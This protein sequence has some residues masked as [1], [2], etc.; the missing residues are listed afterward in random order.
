MTAR[1]KRSC[2]VQQTRRYL[3]PGPIVLV[4]SAHKGESNIMTM[5]W[6]MMA[7]YD[8]IACYIWDQNHSHRLIRGSRECVFNV[9]ELSMAETVV[10]IGNCSGRDTDKF[11]AFGLTKVEGDEVGAPLIA[12]C[13]ASFE[14]RLVDTSL[15]GR[16]SLHIFEVVKAHVAPSPKFPKTIHYRGDGRFMISGEETARWRRLFTPEMLSD[17]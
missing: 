8:A 17:P 2:P 11:A 15:A 1:K 7:G 13:F 12:E 5:G 4:S 6:H 10:K 14:C 9:P 3:E 16:Y